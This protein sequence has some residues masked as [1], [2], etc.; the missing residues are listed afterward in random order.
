[1]GL[2]LITQLAHDV[3]FDSGG[4]GVIV[5]MRFKVAA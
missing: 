1:M 4:E 2:S 5:S 3:R